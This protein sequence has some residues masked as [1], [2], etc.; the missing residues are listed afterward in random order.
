MAC[1]EDLARFVIESSEQDLSD[2]AREQLRIRILDSLGCAIA[3]MEGDTVRVVRAQTEEF[4][5]GGRCSLIGGGTAAPD[6]AAFLNGALVSYLDF[7]DGYIAKGE[8]CHPSGSLAPILA[9]GEYAGSSGRDVITA[10][11]LAYQV[12]CRLSDVAP[13]RA[14]GFDHCTLGAYGVAAGV[15]KVLGLD[16]ARTAHAIAISATGFNTL[17]VVRTGRLSHWDSLAYPHMAACSTRVALLAMAG[18]TGPLDVLEG[19]KGFMDAIAGVF[20]IQWA[21]EDLERV[22]RTVVR[23]HDADIHTQTAIEA[24]LELKRRNAFD[25]ADVEHIDLETFEVAYHVAGGGEEGDRSVVENREEAG[26]SLPY[27]VAAALLDGRVMPEQYR[28]ENI[29][30]PDAQRLLAEVTVRPNAAYSRDFP[31]EMPCRVR[32]RLRDGRVLTKEMREYPGFYT[33]PVS[34]STAREKF[35]T[36][37]APYTTAELRGSIADAVSHLEDIRVADLMGLLARVARTSA[38]TAGERRAS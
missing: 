11:A 3:G 5:G 33:Q 29:R 12:Q 32:L 28:P 31:N 30:R 17:R 9:A 24:V 26:H 34:W 21:G 35:D 25:A 4:D 36:L 6:R 27:V 37:A 23:K 38:G 1:V 16:A 13:V 14:A 22:R 19:E 20:E 7:N 15:A 10:L 18:I 2:A 8:T